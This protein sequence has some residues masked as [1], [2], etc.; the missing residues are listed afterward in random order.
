MKKSVSGFR[1][2]RFYPLVAVA[3]L[4]LL[5]LPGGAAAVDIPPKPG[6]QGQNGTDVQAFIQTTGPNAG[7]WIGDYYSST[8]GDKVPH[9]VQI[10]VPC[11][12][13][14]TKPLT[15][16]L[17][18]PEVA[19][20]NTKG[21]QTDPNNF[22]PPATDEIRKPGER[23]TTVTD[24]S[25]TNTTT[26]SQYADQATF[27]L[28]NSDGLN[29]TRTY[30]PNSGTNSRWVEF[31]TFY[32]NTAG[33]SCG[34]YQLTVTTSDN[35]DN[36]WRLRVGSDP[37]CTV[38]T[39]A[40]GTCSAINQTTSNLLS[41]KNISDDADGVTGTGDELTLALVRT[42]YQHAVGT[43]QADS[44]Q[45]FYFYID[46]N[47]PTIALRNFDMDKDISGS[48]G[49][50]PQTA[51]QYE[52][53]N[54]SVVTGTASNNQSWNNSTVGGGRGTGDV[55]TIGS[56]DVGW[57]N[58]KLCVGGTS[59]NQYI[60]EAPSPV[61]YAIPPQPSMEVSKDDGQ[62]QV[63]PGQQLTYT[64][65]FTN[66]SSTAS[67]GGAA[68]NVTLT[69]TIPTNTTYVSCSIGSPYT[70]TCQN[71]GGEVVYKLNEPVK[72]GASG[73]VYLTVQVKARDQLTDSNVLNEVTLD[74]CDVSN[75][76]YPSKKAQDLD[77]IPPQENPNAITL[78]SFT[79]AREG[80]AVVVRW[81][82]G[83]EVNTFGFH[84]LRSS[85]GNRADAVRVTNSLISSTGRD[86]GGASYMWTDTTAAVGTAYT[87]WLQEVE[88][89]GTTN[90][91]G[92][93][94]VSNTSARW[95]IRLP[96][97]SR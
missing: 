18:D 53:P 79:A 80:E 63:N 57:W 1:Q 10:T 47:S 50:N 71:N 28:T 3:T 68:T 46:G 13:P 56:G 77:K 82:T 84:L 4:L 14:S 45:T 55:F 51:V 42:S 74:Y 95:T 93:A 60:F 65:A 41:N 62:T 81:T 88:S 17:Y 30:L 69:D 34:E 87:Y 38:S 67:G 40:A 72:A 94:S 54:K 66:T 16:A 29:L 23:S 61:F 32:P 15:F 5:M 49:T 44:C 92:P 37:D 90:V 20:P 26:N 86:Q 39:S 9:A 35:D 36:A 70:G 75:T 22:Y 73:K 89:D 24:S 8:T 96:L 12:W 97:L 52:K 6:D 85:T 78:S 27:T 2:Q 48:L 33:Y 58:A 64:I 19:Y 59:Q 11:S 7:V 43:G 83:A 91:Y 21:N 76:C 31:T 25:S